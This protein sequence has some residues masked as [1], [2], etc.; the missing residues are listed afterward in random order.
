MNSN[1]ITNEYLNN[2]IKKKIFKEFE[3]WNKSDF[4]FLLSLLNYPSYINLALIILVNL[5]NWM[6][7]SNGDFFYPLEKVEE[8]LDK[9]YLKN[10][11]FEKIKNQENIKLNINKKKNDIN[12]DED[13]NENITGED[14][15]IND[16]NENID[17]N[18]N[19]DLLEY[20]N[21]ENK[22]FIRYFIFIFLF[23]I[24]F[25]IIHIIS[26][27]RKFIDYNHSNNINKFNNLLDENFLNLNTNSF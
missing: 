5:K 22:Q 2:L 16:I 18:Y 20:F 7:Y 24:F 13:N 12:E 8:I 19:T 4:H 3:E 6:L 15:N 9:Y 11:V 23:F 25:T 10:D 17:F 14:E 26:K 27:P 1:E 21:I